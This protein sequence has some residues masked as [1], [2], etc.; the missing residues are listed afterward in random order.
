MQWNYSQYFNSSQSI[1]LNTTLINYLLSTNQPINVTFHSDT[2]GILQVNLTNATYSYGIDNCTGISIPS[3]STF[4]ISTYDQKTNLPITSN[5]TFNIYYSGI[6]INNP[7]NLYYNVIP[8][9]QSF[10][11]CQYP[12]WANLGG[13]IVSTLTSSGYQAFGFNRY[14]EYFR[15]NFT[16]YLLPIETTSNYITYT[17]QDSASTTLKLQNALMQCYKIIAGVPTLTNEGLSD[18]AGQILFYQDQL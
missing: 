12:A 7:E 3:N 14:G 8:N 6:D 1:S 10:Q 13:N 4:N 11:F 5:G 16:A 17:I 2:A 15:Q 18:V 9:K